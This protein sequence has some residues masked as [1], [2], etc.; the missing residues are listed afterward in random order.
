[1]KEIL[2][3]IAHMFRIFLRNK[4][5]LLIN[6]GLPIIGVLSLVLIFHSTGDPH[7]QVGI[8]DQDQTHLS[9]QTIAFLKELDK[10]DLVLIKEN[11]MQQKIGSGELDCVI[12]FEQGFEKYIQ[13]QQTGKVH[14]LSIKGAEVTGWIKGYLDQYIH[15]LATLYQATQGDPDTFE[16]LY[17]DYRSSS[18]QLETQ[19][20]TDTSNH[21]SMT[22]RII[23]FLILFMLMG[24]WSLTENI[25]KEKENRT[26]YRLLSTPVSGKK[27]VIANIVVNLIMMSIQIL[28]TLLCLVG[29]FRVDTGVPFVSFLFV[30]WMFALIAVGLSLMILSFARS[31]KSGGALHQLIVIPTCLLSGCF[32]P[33]EIMPTYILKIADFLPQRWVLATITELQEGA[34]ITEL[35][36]NFLIFLLFAVAFFLVAI[37]QFGRNQDTRTFL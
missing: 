15:Q 2:W 12:Q 10:V 8:V 36:L 16:K 18:F 9:Q 25:L 22:Y 7:L 4:K 29:I 17:R 28:I 26:F 33:A 20:V 24:A 13:S 3:F 34:Q 23:G 1:M 14:L 11:E 37:Y 31:T 27:Y 6:L 30:L 5:S 32:W 21:Q 19:T 35:S